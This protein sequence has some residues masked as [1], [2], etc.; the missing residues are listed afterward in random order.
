M[1]SQ[2]PSL[3]ENALSQPHSTVWTFGY[4]TPD[5]FEDVCYL[6]VVF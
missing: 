4:N 2:G 5:D 3:F 6:A 1:M